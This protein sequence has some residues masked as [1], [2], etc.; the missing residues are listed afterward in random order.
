MSTKRTPGKF[1]A[2]QLE[3]HLER[4]GTP[5]VDEAKLVLNDALIRESLRQ[6]RN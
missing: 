6:N 3:K 5:R 2:T 4:L 1:M